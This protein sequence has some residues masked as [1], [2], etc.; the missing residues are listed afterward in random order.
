[1]GYFSELAEKRFVDEYIKS[2]EFRHQ[3]FL[4]VESIKKA[5]EV[6][7]MPFFDVH[8]EEYEGEPE[9]FTLFGY[10]LFKKPHFLVK[11]DWKITS[12]KY[13]Y[14]AGE[15]HINHLPH[16]ECVMF[17]KKVTIKTT[18]PL[19]NTTSPE[20]YWTSVLEYL[21]GRGAHRGSLR[22]TVLKLGKASMG[23]QFDSYDPHVFTVTGDDKME[24]PVFGNSMYFIVDRSYIN[25][26]HY[27]EYD[28]AVKYYNDNESPLMI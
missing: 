13:E 19:T 26:D 25:P 18:N 27:D 17:G 8:I 9:Y 24:L 11:K 1:M 12:I 28:M 20:N 5:F 15:F 22:K 3:K 6:F 4:M 10:K 21:D 23:V 2:F 16:A 14:R 7:R